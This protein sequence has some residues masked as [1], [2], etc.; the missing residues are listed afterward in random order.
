LDHSDLNR[1]SLTV[2]ALMFRWL[3]VPVVCDAFVA[4]TGYQRTA[5]VFEMPAWISGLQRRSRR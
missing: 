5:G 4:R 1:S 2:L 3:L